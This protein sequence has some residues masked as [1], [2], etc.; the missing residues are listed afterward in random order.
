ML[1]AGVQVG[2]AVAGTAQ[3]EELVGAGW[4][5][6]AEPL[7]QDAE[8]RGAGGALGEAVTKKGDAHVTLQRPT[9]AS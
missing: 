2:D 6:G 9:C 8:V 4:S 5:I 1:D 3:V 7:P